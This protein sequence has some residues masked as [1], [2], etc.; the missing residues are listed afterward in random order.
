M[1]NLLQLAGT[2]QNRAE[3]TKNQASSRQ[4]GT[5]GLIDDAKNKANEFGNRVGEKTTEAKHSLQEGADKAAN[6]AD[7]TAR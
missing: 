6:R 4:S 7:E 5:G 1:L 2:A 3:E